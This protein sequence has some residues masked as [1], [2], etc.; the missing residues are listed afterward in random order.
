MASPESPDETT[1][2]NVEVDKQIQS[3]SFERFDEILIELRSYKKDMLQ[4]HTKLEQ[5][6]VEVKEALKTRFEYSDQKANIKFFSYTA[7]V[8]C[9]LIELSMT[10]V[11]KCLCAFT[12]EDIVKLL[13]T[14]YIYIIFAAD[15]KL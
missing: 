15:S 12:V 13:L 8:G 10:T 11:S 1:I 9:Y 5:G 3:N 4:N 2:A 14:V 6:I 7:L